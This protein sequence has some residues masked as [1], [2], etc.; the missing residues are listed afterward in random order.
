MTKI[1]LFPYIP[2]TAL[3]VKLRIYTVD[4]FYAWYLMFECVCVRAYVYGAHDQC[5][6]NVTNALSCT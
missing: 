5:L 2:N 4:W 3:L 6:N 1:K